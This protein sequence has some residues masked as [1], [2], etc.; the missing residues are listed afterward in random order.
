PD[1]LDGVDAVVHLAAA[2]IAG[3]FTHAHKRAVRDSRIEPTR[4]LAALSASTQTSDGSVLAA[5]ISASAIGYYG[6]DRGDE[7]LTEDSARGTGF[8]ADVGADWEAAPPP[9]T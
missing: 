7:V 6:A 9:A 1:L 8:L 5:F 2:S 3:R 4:R